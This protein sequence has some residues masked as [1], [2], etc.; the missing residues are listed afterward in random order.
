MHV[1]QNGAE[2]SRDTRVGKTGG[3]CSV[4]MESELINTWHPSEFVKM[5]VLLLHLEELF[6]LKKRVPNPLTR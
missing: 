2:G 4:Q 1:G 6:S 3:V 5:E